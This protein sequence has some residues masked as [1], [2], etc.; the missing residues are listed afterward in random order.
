MSPTGLGPTQPT[1]GGNTVLDIF[2]ASISKILSIKL[3]VKNVDMVPENQ[4]LEFNLLFP[5]GK[6]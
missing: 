2:Y 5:N 3:L 1:L 4:L 6:E